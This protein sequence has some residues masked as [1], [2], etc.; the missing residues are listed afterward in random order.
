MPKRGRLHRW[1][2]P[3]LKANAGHAQLLLPHA[4]TAQESV[5]VGGPVFNKLQSPFSF[6]ALENSNWIIVGVDSA[7]NAGK[8]SLYMNGSLGKDTQFSFFAAANNAVSRS[9]SLWYVV[10][11]QIPS[12]G[13]NRDKGILPFRDGFK[14]RMK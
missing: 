5:A 3:D 10:S 9:D 2:S 13:P 7:Y 14:S 8:Q 1:S 12:F 11:R 4:K 6:F